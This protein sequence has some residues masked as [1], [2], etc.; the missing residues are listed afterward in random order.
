MF[1]C[2]VSISEIVIILLVMIHPQGKWD[3]GPVVGQ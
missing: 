3:Q 2:Q 1:M